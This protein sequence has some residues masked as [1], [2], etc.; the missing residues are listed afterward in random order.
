MCVWC[1]SLSVCSVYFCVQLQVPLGVRFLSGRR[2]APC[3]V[4]VSQELQAK[5]GDKAGDRGKHEKY[6]IIMPPH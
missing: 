3:H 4:V 6:M 5:H 1:I 2:A